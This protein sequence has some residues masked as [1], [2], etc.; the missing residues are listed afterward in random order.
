MELDRSLL[1]TLP[2]L[3]FGCAEKPA[4]SAEPA[5]PA[6]P[7]KTESA[8]PVA[9]ADKPAP[10]VK[11]TLRPREPLNVLLLTVDALR[12]DMPWAGYPRDIAPNLTRFAKQNVVFENHRSV[13]SFTAQSVPAILSGRPASTLYR[14]GYFFAGYQDSNEFFP[15]A[16]SAKGVRTVGVQSHLYFNRGKGLNQGFAIWDMVPG[17]TFNERSD[18]HITSPKTHELMV[19]HLSNPENVKGQF[20]AWTHYTDPHHQWIKHAES[21]DFGSS[22]RDLYDNEV[23]YTDQHVGKLLTWAEKQPWW[24]RTA[25]VISA[26]HGEAFGE[27]G[28]MQHAHELYEE[29]VRVP[30]IVR[31]P[32]AEPR[33]VATP[34]THVDLAPTIMEL[35]GQEALTGF[36]GES[37]VP[38]IDGKSAQPK[39]V[40]LELCA[41][42]VQPARRA[43]VSGDWKLIRFGD[44]AGPEKLFNLKSDPGEK[45]DLAKSEPEKLSE[46]RGLLD[47][48]F[49]KLPT[50]TPHGG[51]KLKGGGVADGPLRPE[52]A[53]R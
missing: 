26:D 42:N 24:E 47:S 48:Q 37:L 7:T 22:E 4:P 18:D 52:L 15:E 1:L 27:H 11:K 33:R 44:K 17:I 16:L 41:D 45:K 34:H 43:V 14:S 53:A 50:V 30:L 38:E 23:H 35:M 25:V 28:M 5:K 46:M 2:L 19:K 39:P 49:A 31:V 36:T 21:P 6:E 13:S 8:A 40:V 29:L 32:G 51:M 10:V 20:F 12:A 3:M 9:P